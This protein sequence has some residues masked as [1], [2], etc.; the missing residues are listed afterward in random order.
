M[1]RRYYSFLVGLTALCGLG[2]G[3]GTDEFPVAEATGQVLCEGKPVANVRVWFSPKA[4]GNS[5]N[6]GKQGNAVT[7]TEGRFVVSTYET[8]DGAVIGSHEI[9]VSR[10]GETTDCPCALDMAQPVKVV[11]VADGEDN[12]FT[13]E[14]PKA[15]PGRRGQSAVQEDEDD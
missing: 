8:E 1:S 6:S 5:A 14:L 9:T 11:E 13:I 4:T 12:D 3:G 7:D 10:T 2:C 15:R